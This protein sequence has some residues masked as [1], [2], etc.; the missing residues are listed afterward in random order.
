[1]TLSMLVPAVIRVMGLISTNLTV[2]VADVCGN[3]LGRP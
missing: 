2:L 1:M 3:H